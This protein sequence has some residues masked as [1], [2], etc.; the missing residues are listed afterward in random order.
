MDE[1]RD[2]TTDDAATLLRWFK[3]RGGIAIWA[4]LG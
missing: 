3:E 2:I 1:P 4:S